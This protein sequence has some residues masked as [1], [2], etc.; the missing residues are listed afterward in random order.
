VE[1]GGG[2]AVA[3]RTV[4]EKHRAQ[5]SASRFL[6][7]TPQRRHDNSIINAVVISFRSKISAMLL[8]ITMNI[9]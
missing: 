2:S 6:G 7:A 9:A 8:R 4:F 3:G 5:A 1:S